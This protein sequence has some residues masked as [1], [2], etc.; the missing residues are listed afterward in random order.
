MRG[1]QC[2]VVAP[3]APFA[4]DVRVL[5]IAGT[6]QQAEAYIRARGL[7]SGARFEYVD[8]FEQLYGLDISRCEVVLLGTWA[9]RPDAGLLLRTLHARALR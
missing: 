8:H 5:V 7:N 4:A 6:R 9:Q 3:V 2:P 1:D